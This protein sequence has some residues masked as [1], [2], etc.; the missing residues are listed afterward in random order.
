[1]KFAYYPGCTAKST[2]IEYEESVRETSQSLGIDLVEIPD[3]TCCGA[4]SGHSVN[5]ELALALPSRNLAIANRMS[6][7]LVSACPACSLRHK[8]AQH[9]LEGDP[10]LRI[11]LAEDIG[12]PLELP[13]KPRHFLEVL[14]HDIGVDAIRGKVRN[15]LKGLR[16]AAYYG[17]Y[18]VRPP[19]I[20]AFDDP[21]N[22]S[23]MDEVMEALGAE[24]VDWSHKVEC[25]GGGLA[26]VAPEVV[27]KL[28][29]RIAL[30]A[31]AVGADAIVTACS[32]CHANLDM[33]QPRRH[34]SG[35]LPIF[36]F[37]EL[38]ALAFGSSNGRRWMAKHL[39]DPAELLEK[40]KLL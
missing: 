13:P 27:K 40:L 21:E 5:R 24:V 1:M 34:G 23:V 35:P 25:C 38:A 17:C 33:R 10:E 36:Y 2:A 15:P 7:G 39:V 8:V 9:E 29:G 6:L 18:L 30:A 32:I 28:V 4:S 11:R 19:E 20:A 12:Q 37:S 3:W 31:S 14:Y 26:V 16:V 22:P